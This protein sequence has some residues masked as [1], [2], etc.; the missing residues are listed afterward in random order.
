MSLMLVRPT[1]RVRRR[2]TP[3]ATNANGG[4]IGGSGSISCTLPSGV[5]PGDLI[6]ACAS[7]GS[8]QGARS[9]STPAGYD[10]LLNE[11]GSGNLRRFCI[12]YR[13]ATGSDSGVTASTSGSANWGISIVVIRNAKFGVAP[14]IGITDT[15]TGTSYDPPGVTP[16][17]APQHMYS[18]VMLGN[19]VARTPSAPAGYST[20]V[21]TDQ[22]THAYGR[23]VRI[24]AVENPPSASLGS[25][26]A[27]AAQTVLVRGAS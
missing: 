8:T 23:L 15:A 5:L 25:S 10:E 2:P 20:L 14:E 12:W 9:L 3:I 16:S 17:F 6:L 22:Y 27:Y 18:V 1:L 13:W 21:T 24:G 11:A 7:L 4:S 26:V 19:Q